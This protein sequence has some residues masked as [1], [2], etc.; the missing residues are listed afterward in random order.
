[1]VNSNPI[2]NNNFRASIL[3]TFMLM[4]TRK[5]ERIGVFIEVKLVG[6]GFFPKKPLFLQIHALGNPT[7]TSTG[8]LYCTRVCFS[9]GATRKFLPTLI[10]GL[11]FG[12]WA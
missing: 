7:P 8:Q 4:K 5:I 6:V 11:G 2:I 12:L 10:N 9:L 3:V 1:M